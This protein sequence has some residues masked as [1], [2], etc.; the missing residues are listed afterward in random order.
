[1]PSD[2][3]KQCS[4]WIDHLFQKDLPYAY[5]RLANHYLNC[6]QSEHQKLVEIDLPSRKA[7]AE[8]IPELI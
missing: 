2:M 1:M 7:V 4:E 3:E 5:N 6:P 8:E